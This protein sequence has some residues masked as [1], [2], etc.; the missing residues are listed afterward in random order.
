[1]G[2]GSLRGT[3][4]PF[5]EMLGPNPQTGIDRGNV[6]FANAPYPLATLTGGPEWPGRVDHNF[7]QRNHVSGRYTKG[8]TLMTPMNVYFSGFITDSGERN[9]NFLLSDA[10]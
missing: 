2:P 5:M 8:S 9:Q 4:A 10:Y 7:S 1:N 6:Q 3:G